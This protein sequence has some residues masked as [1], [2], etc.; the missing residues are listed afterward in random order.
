MTDNMMKIAGRGDDGLSKALKMDNYGNVCVKPTGSIV[1]QDGEGNDVL[2]VADVAPWAYNAANQTNRVE[3]FNAYDHINDSLKIQT[4]DMQKIIIADN[5]EL[6]T[7]T[8]RYYKADGTM[9]ASTLSNVEPI[10]GWNSKHRNRSLVVYS[11]LDAS[12]EIF[13]LVRRDELAFNRIKN[14][15]GVENKVTIPVTQSYESV[16]ICPD[17]LPFLGQ[18]CPEDVSIGIKAETIPTTGY[19]YISLAL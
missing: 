8:R 14:L 2:R 18:I 5:V 10:V 1:T 17:D 11:T 13:F 6:R 4:P 9:S 3:I 19:I 7:D 12:I 15:D 16:Y